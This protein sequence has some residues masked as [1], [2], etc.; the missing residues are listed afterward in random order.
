[1]LKSICSKKKSLWHKKLKKAR[2]SIRKNEWIHKTIWNKKR[3]RRNEKDNVREL[4]QRAASRRQNSKMET[5][6]LVI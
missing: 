4:R 5:S 6:K 2:R 3:R 1:L